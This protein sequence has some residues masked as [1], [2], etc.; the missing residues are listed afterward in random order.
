VDIP[1]E[2]LDAVKAVELTL[3]AMPGINGVG[4]GMRESDGEIFDEL[5]IRIL[6]DDASEVPEGVPTEIAGV[7]ICIIERRYEPLASP[8][9]TRYRDLHGGIHITNPRQVDH[10]TLGAIVQDDSAISSGQ[11]LGLSCFHVVGDRGSLFPD[12]VWQPDNPPLTPTPVRPHRDN[13]GKV[14]RASFPN[15]PFPLPGLGDIRLG[16]FDAA[17]FSLDE[18]FDSQLPPAD[19]RT[20]SRAIMGQDE[21]QPNL[22]DAIT[23]TAEAR[24]TLMEVSKRGAM[25]RVTHGR[26]VA[27]RMSNEW[28]WSPLGSGSKRFILGSIEIM[29]DT[30]EQPDGIF[31]ITGDSGSVVLLREGNRVLPTAV[32]LLWGGSPSGA[33]GLMTDINVLESEL[34]I[35]MVWA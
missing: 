16:L 17:V 9:L 21:Q 5:A 23:A 26:V 2:I 31:A 30:V 33:W 15:T 14:Q 10:G 11:L 19:Q 29:F 6:V 8:D 7:D 18:A 27:P 12:T 4:V 20:I 22:A 35:S 32:G 25:T 34:E 3:L 24:R 28:V 1:P 13:I